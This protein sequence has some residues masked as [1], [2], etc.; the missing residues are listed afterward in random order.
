MCMFLPY[1]LSDV[2]SPL[3]GDLGTHFMMLLSQYVASKGATV[4]NLFG[5]EETLVTCA[6]GLF[7]NAREAG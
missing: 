2:G 1:V 4:G 5:L 6:H 3:S 7:L